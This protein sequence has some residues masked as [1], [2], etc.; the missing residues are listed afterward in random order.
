MMRRSWVLQCAIAAMCFT[1]TACSGLN[2]ASTTESDAAAPAPGAAASSSPAPTPQPPP[3]AAAPPP[4]PPVAT[5]PAPAPAPVP[6]ATAPANRPTPATPP[7]VANRT[8]PAPP[9]GASSPAVTVAPRA[10]SEPQTSRPTPPAPVAPVTPPAPATVVAAPPP[11]ASTLD[12]TSLGTRL[13]ETKAIGVM[14]KISVKNQADDLLE[15]FRAYHRRQSAV[16]LADLRNSY[17]LLVLKI[18]SLVQDG[19]P[20]LAKEIDRSRAAIWEILADQRK[21]IESNLMSGA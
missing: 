18:L 6:S 3:V 8:P 16:S 9:A 11:P 7:P 19:D 2:S 10:A 20:P 17:E 14:T 13:R 1:A 5:T 21:F 4:A 15:K 12:F